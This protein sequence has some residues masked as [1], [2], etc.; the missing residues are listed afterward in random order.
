MSDLSHPQDGDAVPGAPRAGDGV[1]PGSHDVPES[2]RSWVEPGTFYVVATPIGNLADLSGRALSVLRQVDLVACEDTRHARKLL[3][4]FGIRATMLSAHEHNEAGRAVQ[5]AEKLGTGLSVALISDAGTPA[6]SDPGTLLV[7]QIRDAGH[8]VVPVPGPSAVIAALSAS[9]L[10]SRHFWFE[11]FL[12]PKA[13]GRQTRLAELVDMPATLAFYEA[14]HRITGMLRDTAA[15]LG[16]QRRAVIAREL[17]KRF[18]QIVSG[19]VAELV[20]QLDDGRIPSRGEFVVLVEGAMEQVPVGAV[21]ADSGALIDALLA[22]G[23]AAKA[24]A[25]ALAHVLPHSR[26]ELYQE[27]LSRKQDTDK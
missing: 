16:D 14:P 25:K 2:G 3:D 12:P 5:I 26:N 18:E 23:V 15:V 7:R 22:E 9:G 4:H 19:S 17:T 1:L 20:E 13:S 6:I 24:I 11:G 21:A 10:D 8:P 27:V